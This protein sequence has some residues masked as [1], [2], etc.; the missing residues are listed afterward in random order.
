MLLSGRA[1]RM[2]GHVFTCMGVTEHKGSGAEITNTR[3]GAICIILQGCYFS[4]R[5]V[6]KLP[7]GHQIG[8]IG[9][10]VLR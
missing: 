8:A 2:T 7:A 10:N 6:A 1:V 5:D 9:Q 3:W 4:F